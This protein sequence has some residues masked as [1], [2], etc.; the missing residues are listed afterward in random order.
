MKKV[1]ID[2]K[3]LCFSV[4][5]MDD[6]DNKLYSNN[7]I[8]TNTISDVLTAFEVQRLTE[9]GYKQIQGETK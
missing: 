4:V 6:I 7:S 5:D 8:E 9:N 2:P 1:Q 3:N